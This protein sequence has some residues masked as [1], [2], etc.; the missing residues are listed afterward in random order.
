MKEIMAVLRINMMNKTKEALL[1]EGFESLN[2]RKVLG[3]GKK[4]I[5]FSLIQDVLLDNQ[6]SSPVLAETVS[7]GHRLIAKRLLSMVVK[8]EDAKKVVD[9]IIQVNST[10]NPGDGKI[11]VMPVSNVIRIRNGDQDNEAL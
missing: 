3:R 4:K 6:Y 8:D 1:K 10:G 5:D 11:F 9:T 7:E 2:C